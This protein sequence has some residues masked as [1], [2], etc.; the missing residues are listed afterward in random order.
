MRRKRI[1][2]LIA[3]GGRAR[4]VK[5]LNSDEEREIV[6]LDFDHERI[7]MPPDDRAGRSFASFGKSRSGIELHT[8]PVR[9]NERLFAEMLA[10]DLA[11]Q[12]GKGH[13]DALIVAAAP[14]T[15]GDL[16][17]AYPASLAK[18]VVKE[19]DKDYTRLPDKALTRVLYSLVNSRV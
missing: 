9:N 1:W 18:K 16:R 7:S 8:D 3:N 12:A 5:Y 6:D 10:T 15:L 2:A 13:F 4:V 11:Q 19:I 17:S 14:R